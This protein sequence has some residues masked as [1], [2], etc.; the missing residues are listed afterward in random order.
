MST[1]PP[2]PP[3]TLPAPPA[4]Q[5]AGAPDGGGVM[6][7]DVLLALQKT[8]SRLSGITA[9]RNAAELRSQPRALIV[10]DV[11]FDITLNV[12]P[13]DI[14][15]G[16]TASDSLV[17]RGDGTGFALRLQGRIATDIR[18]EEAPQRPPVADDASRTQDTGGP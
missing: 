12:A 1:T 4:G 10:G 11:A 6:L 5:V 16:K 7:T 15:A 18:H 17:Y 14:A 2:G 13:A 3:P 8:F 9:E